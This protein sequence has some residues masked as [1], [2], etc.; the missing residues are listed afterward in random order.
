[1]KR[2]GSPQKGF[3]RRAQIIDDEH[4]SAR[5]VAHNLL[6]RDMPRGPTLFHEQELHRP[7]EPLLEVLAKQLRPFDPADVR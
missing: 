6:P 3:A 1:M 2:P 5:G 4:V 7:A